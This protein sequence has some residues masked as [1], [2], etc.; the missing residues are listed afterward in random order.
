[1]SRIT[2]A[3]DE[4]TLTDE[5]RHA[6]RVLSGPLARPTH[7]EM[8][9][10]VAHPD[11]E[12]DPA[13]RIGPSSVTSSPLIRVALSMLGTACIKGQ[14]ARRFSPEAHWWGDLVVAH[15]L[16]DAGGD[17]WHMMA[18]N[19][20][21]AVSA[22]IRI[23]AIEA[24]WRDDMDALTPQELQ[25]VT[26]ARQ[27]LTGTVTDDSWAREVELVGSE[28]GVVELTIMY[29]YLALLMRAGQAFGLQPDIDNEQLAEML[30]GLRA[31]TWPLIDVSQYSQAFEQ[32][33]FE[34]IRLG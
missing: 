2:R 28:R 23:E 33:I 31:G 13:K 25:Y 17:R 20:S 3:T 8:L 9:N 6:L 18:Q 10:R 24:L 19:A 30:A 27:V 15:D 26:Y 34:R 22:G 14:A 21:S 7:V 29:L 5:D 4:Q 16:S 11:R 32:D 1:M 12:K